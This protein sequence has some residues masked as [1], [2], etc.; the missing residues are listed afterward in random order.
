MKPVI[1]SLSLVAI[2]PIK[3]PSIAFVRRWWN[4]GAA[5]FP[6]STCWFVAAAARLSLSALAARTPD[7]FSAGV[8][9]TDDS[10]HTNESMA[11]KKCDDG[12]NSLCLMS[13][14]KLPQPATIEVVLKQAYEV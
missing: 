12:K 9:Y 10:L 3:K 5:R 1:A 13:L 7:L 14:K 11:R 4:G 8:L 2:Q 6:I